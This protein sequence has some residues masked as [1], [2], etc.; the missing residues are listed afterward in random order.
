MQAATSP[1]LYRRVP[2]GGTGE[3]VISDGPPL[4]GHWICRERL[5][6]RLHDATRRGL[7]LLLGPP[8]SGKTTL[9]SGWAKSNRFVRTLWLSSD[10]PLIALAE[11]IAEAHL[12]PQK[13]TQTLIVMDDI[14]LIAD[15]QLAAGL[16]HLMAELSAETRLILIGR[17]CGSLS[18]SKLALTAQVTEVG[19]EELR[20]TPA[21]AAALVTKTTGHEPAP[22]DMAALLDHTQGWAAGI[23]LAASSPLNAGDMRTVT[24][25]LGAIG[26]S[27]WDYFEREVCGLL[28]ATDLDFLVRVSVARSF[29]VDFCEAVTSRADAGALLDYFVAQQLF[30]SRC[31]EEA[32][33][34]FHPLFGSHLAQHLALEGRAVMDDVHTRAGEWFAENDEVEEAMRHFVLGNRMDKALALGASQVIDQ[35]A[36]GLLPSRRCLLPGGVPDSYFARE[37]IRMYPLGA[38]LVCASR[39]DEAAHW[40]SRF[41]I[42][43]GSEAAFSGH[44]ARVEC[45]WA[46][47]AS[48]AR[49]ADGVLAHFEA[50]KN[51]LGKTGFAANQESDPPWV[52]ALDKSILSVL[53]WIVARAY[54]EAGRFEAA[55]RVLDSQRHLGHLPTGAF[56]LGPL[57]S[58][59]LAAGR[60]REAAALARRAI[61]ESEQTYESSVLLVESHIVLA[62]VLYERDE[63]AEARAELLKA[64]SLAIAS[65][66]DRWMVVTDC[67]IARVSLAEGDPRRALQQLQTLREAETNAWLSP[68]L[69]STIAHLEFR[70][71]LSL[72]DL[73]RAEH[74]LTR[75]APGPDLADNMA[76][77]HLCSG[78]PDRAAT[79]LAGAPTEPLRVR[80]EIERMLLQARINLQ[81]GNPAAAEHSLERAID[82][83]RPERF[84]RVFREEPKQIVAT[85]SRICSH[86]GDS[87]IDALL[88]K[89]ATETGS[90]AGSG[91]TQVLEPLT[92]RERE[93]V[94]FLPSHLTQSEIARKMYISSNTVKTH[95][96]GL[97][98]KLG[99]TSRAEAVELAQACGL[100]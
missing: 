100:L 3:P 98:R 99:A 81:L 51:L 70:C 52:A 91:P 20:F 67:E 68:S 30:L 10:E 29:T 69:L 58:V 61:D 40:L 31:R 33:Y 62:G 34:T 78:R 53:P 97:Y 16:E 7:T 24:D 71:R 35:L 36:V 89:T 48:V 25:Q 56:A 82:T 32:T 21:E 88:A 26:G 19:A 49:D 95:M 44:R 60:L 27:L 55:K 13:R 63:L 22:D 94:V 73:D 96:K 15:R 72:G 45:L 90:P 6:L 93:L 11:S 14:H 41:E 8:G 83:G 46:I 50:A 28:T 17:H 92:E 9:V 76:R 75:M 86:R 2:P 5:H 42:S 80:S 1:R 38:S 4:P 65:G 87:Y 85:L 66:L 12:Q 37:P 59:A 77:V 18:R 64:R 47:H 74:I 84:I 79:V 43:V 57:A 54:A 39:L 23:R